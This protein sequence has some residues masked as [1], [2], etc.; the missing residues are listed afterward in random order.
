VCLACELE[1]DGMRL[2]FASTHLALHRETRAAAIKMLAEKL[3]ADL[4]LVLAGDFNAGVAELEPLATAGLTVP[5]S[6]PPSFPSLR[7]RSPLDHIAFSA[8][9]ELEELATVRSLA[10]DHLP[11]V[12]ELRLR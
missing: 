1:V 6:P 12:A 2:R 9:W 5:Q 10:S 8:H 11:V 4:P 7:A 3:P